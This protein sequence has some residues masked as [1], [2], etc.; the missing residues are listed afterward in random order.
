MLANVRAVQ[1]DDEEESVPSRRQRVGA[2][3][4][5]VAAFP[6]APESVETVQTKPSTEGRAH[7]GRMSSQKIWRVPFRQ[8]LTSSARSSSPPDAH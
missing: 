6:V 7:A 4:R 2:E 5:R 3:E 1:S 8:A